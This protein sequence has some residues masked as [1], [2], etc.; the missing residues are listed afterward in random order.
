ML[1]FSGSFHGSQLPIGTDY[2]ILG[3]LLKEWNKSVNA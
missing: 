2:L 3:Q 1:I